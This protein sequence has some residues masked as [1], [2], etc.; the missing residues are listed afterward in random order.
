[1]PIY[2]GHP[3]KCPDRICKYNYCIV[4]LFMPYTNLPHFK[5]YPFVRLSVCLIT[6]ILLQWYLQFTI[7]VLVIFSCPIVFVLLLFI[8]LSSTL[9]FS[10]QWLRGVCILLLFVAAGAFITYTRD[11]RHH[12]NWVG[13]YYRPGQNILLTIEE[14]LVEK[15]NSYKALASINAIGQ[16]TVWRKVNGKVILYFYKGKVKPALHYCSQ[17]IINKALSPIKN[18]GNPGAFD[19]NQYC[20]FRGITYEEFLYPGEYA[21]PA[22]DNINPMQNALF[23]LRDA[24]INVIQQNIPG[25]REQGVAE[26][27][28]IGYRGN[29]D[30]DLL[31]EY[32]NAGVVHIIAISGLH[33]AMIYGLLLFIFGLFPSNRLT[34]ILKPVVILLV[35]W[36]AALLAGAMPSIIRAAIMFSF[37]IVGQALGRRT[38]IYNTLA[39]SAFCMLV[40]NPFYLWDAGFILSYAAVISIALFYRPVRNWLFFKNKILEKIW[41][42]TAI[43]IA[44]QILAI[45]IILFYFHQL[46]NFFLVANFI[47]VPLS[48]AILYSGLALLCL[49]FIPFVTK[50]L[51][52]AVG[53]MIQCLD[54][55]IERVSHLP[56]AVWND[57]YADGI[58]TILLYGCI[59]AACIWLLR[60]SRKSLFA[61]LLFLAAIIIYTSVNLMA[62]SRQ[63]K[64]IVYNIPHQTAVDVIQGNRCQ[65]IGDSVLLQDGP[66]QKYDLTP[67][68]IINRVNSQADTTFKNAENTCIN[69]H[70]TRIFLL[71]NTF[72]IPETT[73]K[74]AVDVLILSK[75]PKLTIPALQNA[76]TFKQLVFDG[77]NQMGKIRR[78]K[79]DCDSL[80]L[81]FYSVPEQGA[82]VMDIN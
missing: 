9:K 66:L 20:L 39:A 22:N 44:V 31:Q 18:S 27:L 78:W 63:Q 81:R 61:S 67:S 7:P 33:L 38:N 73:N 77:S 58:L 79:K 13:K 40:Y 16:D 3:E 12:P 32:S 34:G 14:P 71:D 41:E 59:I 15:A 72:I 28:L 80:H 29:L 30:A 75:N 49:S 10:L 1:M 46:A 43:T 76:F 47:A 52:M 23:N 8:L 42:A 68:R 82:F 11:I 70:N 2:S 74:I 69:I 60:K 57:V 36:L 35:L 50:W 54:S 56:F 24:T 17:I 4:H 25:A 53:F 5:K 55:F 37:I 21:S 51:G 65:F 48:C 45:P 62:S 26:A 64:M 19:Y 6:G